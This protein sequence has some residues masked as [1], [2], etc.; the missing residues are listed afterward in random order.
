MGHGLNFPNFGRVRETGK[1]V[2]AAAGPMPTFDFGLP[3]LN[4]Q[5]PSLK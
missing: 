2:A 1:F 4:S 3:T 5:L